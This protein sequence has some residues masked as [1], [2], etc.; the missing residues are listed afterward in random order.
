M[1]RLSQPIISDEEINEVTKVLKSGMLVQG[2][3]VEQF[4]KSLKQY[5][6]ADYTLAVSSGTAA[7][8]LALAALDIK[9]GD[10]VF[11]PAFTFPATANV[12]E[13]QRARPVLVDVEMDT[14]NICPDKLEESIKNWTGAEKPRAIIV[15]HEFGA[16]CN[17]KRIMGIAQKY[18][19]YVIEDAACALG[20]KFQEK[21]VGTFGD[22]GCF[23][24]H[25]RKAITTGEGGALVTKDEK[26]YTR[27]KML[28][29]HGIHRDESG[30]ID[31]L[32][33]G[34]NYRL[35]DFQ[36]ILGDM[37]LKKFD[38][39]LKKREELINVYI[40]ELEDNH[41]ISLPFN[42][43]GH[44]WQTFMVVLPIDIHRKQ[45]MEW[46]FEK[47]IETNL[48][49][50]AIHML[51]YYKEKYNFDANTYPIAKRLYYN[52]LALPLHPALLKEEVHFICNT[53]K[54]IL[55]G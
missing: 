30:N 51:Q 3:Y 43:E 37:Q 27:L 40:E 29:N 47:K 6:G 52:G 20:T 36:A 12:V 9:Q 22:I 16:P 1:I 11:I 19:L 14:Y 49:A 24:W 55:K 2:K 54:K 41:K 33:P 42:I 23:S 46:M 17:M 34:F 7:L 15:V 32:L 8:H 38:Q 25:P 39:W 21:H 4:E 5:I 18:N 48:G 28:R 26:L 35:T 50:Q 31:F 45:I 44:A 13:I 53:F 10:A